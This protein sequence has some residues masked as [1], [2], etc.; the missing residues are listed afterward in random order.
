[1]FLYIQNKNS[2]TVNVI[3]NDDDKFIIQCSSQ[4]LSSLQNFMHRLLPLFNEIIQALKIKGQ[5]AVIVTKLMFDNVENESIP[6]HLNNFIPED[7]M[8]ALNFYSEAQDTG[9]FI[10]EVLTRF[11]NRRLWYLPPINMSTEDDSD[12]HSEESQDE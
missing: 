8:A 4:I 1:M 7:N 11:E 2:I 5:R 6:K 12:Y 10:I 9:H 3:Y